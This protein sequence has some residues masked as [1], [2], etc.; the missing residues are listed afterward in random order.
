MRTSPPT[1]CERRGFTLIELL[2]VMAV[3][4]MLTMVV[5]PAFQAMFQSERERELNRFAATLRA[6]CTEAV[7]RRLPYRLEVDLPEQRYIPQQREDDGTF[8]PIP[9]TRNLG[10]HRF[11][12]SIQMVDLLPYGATGGP[13]TAHPVTIRIDATGFVDPFLLHLRSGTED[14]TVRVEF[15]CHPQIL[16]GYSDVL[17]EE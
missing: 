9:N 1:S 14:W 2:V 5:L 10:E 16:A 4:V 6:L 13:I 15:T 3:V 11:P 17:L 12:E 7:L 8:G